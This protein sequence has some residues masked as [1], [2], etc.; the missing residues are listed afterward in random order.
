MPKAVKYLLWVVGIFVLFAIFRSPDAAANL[1][2]DIVDLIVSA[3]TAVFD[4]F[5]ALLA[6]FTT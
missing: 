6:A 3:I 5:D 2:A 4:F 1:V